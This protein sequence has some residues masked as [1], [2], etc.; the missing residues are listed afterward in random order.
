MLKTDGSWGGRGVVMV[1]DESRL[2][3]TWASISSPPSFPRAFKRL[4]VNR[5]TDMVV[6]RLRG[7][8]PVV[9][10]QQ[11]LTGR[12]AIVTVACQDG[13]VRELICLE[14]VRGADARGPAEVVRVIDHPG[15]A[16]AA[17][18]VVKRF[19]LS[20]F[21]GMDF[22]IADDGE[23]YMIELNPRVTPT[24]YL[25]VEGGHEVGQV[26]TLFPSDE[27]TVGTLDVPLRSLALTELGERLTARRAGALNRMGRRLT[28]RL[29]TR[30]S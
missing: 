22:L 29:N 4:V 1:P 23:A 19:G 14:V 20:G 30:R 5:D 8:R 3:P 6:A 16:N 15:M 12:D 28:Q 26:L 17:R 18:Q 9:N 13:L 11:H 25:L 2:A 24:C 21:C 10:A 27:A 7:R